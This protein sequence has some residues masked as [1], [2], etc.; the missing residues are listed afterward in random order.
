MSKTSE[1]HRYIYIFFTAVGQTNHHTS[2]VGYYFYKERNYWT[3]GFILRFVITCG[4]SSAD[5]LKRLTV[6]YRKRDPKSCIGEPKDWRRQVPF[7]TIFRLV[8]RRKY[9]QKKTKDIVLDNSSSTDI[10]WNLNISRKS[11]G[12]IMT[13]SK[14]FWKT[15]A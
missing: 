5:S 3:T 7:R 1:M 14:F 15:W 8:E 6:F 10:T 11:V 12:P 13:D 2:V 9:Q 4:I